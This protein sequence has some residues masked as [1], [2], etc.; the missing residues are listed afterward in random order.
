ML[1]NNLRRR[2]LPSAAGVAAFLLFQSPAAMADRIIT[3]NGRVLE[4]TVED[5]DESTYHIKLAT[6]EL[7][8]PKSM[9][10]EI[11]VEGDMSK[12]KP[13]DDKEKD[14]LEK[15]FV[16][17]QNQWMPKAQYEQSLKKEKDKIK[18]HLDEE[19]KHLQ[20]ADGWKF[21]TAHFQIQGN[22]PKEKLDDLAA[23]LEE[24]YK[25]M[26]TQIGMKASGTIQRKK[27]VVNVY[28]D[29][30]D[31]LKSGGAPGG[32]AG[33]FSNEQETLNFYYDF[34]D[35]GFTRHVML[36]E[37]THLLTYLCNPKF[38]PPSWINEGMAE[39]FGSSKTGETGKR[40][41]EPGQIL[42]NRLL[43]LQEM[44]KGTA[45]TGK[46]ASITDAYVP[47]DKW[48]SF[49]ASYHEA[50]AAKA[51][52]YQMYSYWWAFCHF[53]CTHKT[54]GKKFFSYFKD[55]YA[56]QGFKTKTGYGGNDT[57]GVAFKVEP[58]EYTEKLMQTL[59]VKDIKKLDEEFRT[60][61]KAQEP[62]GARGYF[63]VGRDLCMQRKYDEALVKLD[64]AIAKGYDTADTYIYRS[65]CWRGKNQR[66]KQVED[67][68]KAIVNNPV[69]P[70]YRSELASALRF[71]KEGR[72]EAIQQIKLAVELDPLNTWY[73]FILSELEKKD[74][75]K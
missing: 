26:N 36:H 10:K 32:T 40:K 38:E 28:R 64:Q 45:G 8:I 63:Y 61:I 52:V 49:S 60:W 31:Y 48:L 7:D 24:Y 3:K 57:G 74:D 39:Y 25:F 69:E 27:M 29:E 14:M 16:R 21:E 58:K 12:Y 44:E 30:E 67:L 65:R 41:M 42:D 71:D 9:V 43:V 35:E 46:D 5:K 73:P 50:S 18:K 70:T 6:A 75:D 11:L 13:K 33:Y 2:W 72:A 23:L 55:L 22:C 62:V 59:G 20:F 15:G 34:E 53:M 68:R 17:Y 37:G 56:L 66:D 51:S 54:Y 47:L 19:A 4:G 1:K